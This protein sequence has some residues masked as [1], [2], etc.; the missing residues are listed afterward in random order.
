[1]RIPATHTFTHLFSHQTENKTPIYTAGYVIII[2]APVYNT[3]YDTLTLLPSHSPLPS[4]PPPTM[5]NNRRT[6][7]S[8]TND[9]ST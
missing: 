6:T 9:K 5:T 4:P 1:M 3:Y 2:I 7:D 8:A